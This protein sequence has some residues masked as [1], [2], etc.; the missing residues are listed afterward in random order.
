MC[1]HMRI[2]NNGIH[3]VRLSMYAHIFVAMYIDFL[4]E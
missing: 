3:G 2:I 4:H 1:I